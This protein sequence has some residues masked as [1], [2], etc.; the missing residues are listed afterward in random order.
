[1]KM[2]MH[3]SELASVEFEPGQELSWLHGD[4]HRIATVIKVEGDKVK[5]SGLTT[6]YWLSKLVLTKKI[7]RPYPQNWA[8]L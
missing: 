1:M 3:G 8:G 7:Q 6:E 2:N 4:D 5:L